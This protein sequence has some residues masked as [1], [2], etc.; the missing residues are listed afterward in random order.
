MQKTSSNL[1]LHNEVNTQQLENEF[2]HCLYNRKIHSKF[3]FWGKKETERYLEVCQQKS[4]IYHHR[5]LALWER[6]VSAILQHIHQ[7]QGTYF[8]FITLGMRDGVADAYLLHALQKYETFSYI[9]V[10]ISE[11]AIIYGLRGTVFQQMGEIES[12]NMDY[13]DFSNFSTFSSRVR[14]ENYHH[15]CIVFLGNTIG[16]LSNLAVLN[17]LRKGMDEGDYLII[18]AMLQKKGDTKTMML[19]VEHSMDMY[20]DA[21]FEQYLLTPLEKVGI[22][23]SHGDIEIVYSPNRY[24]P[25]L[26]NMEVFFVFNSNRTVLYLDQEIPF[27]KGGKIRL[28]QVYMYPEETMIELLETLNFKVEEKFISSSKMVGIY[29]CTSRGS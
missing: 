29:L 28:M 21:A 24:Y 17:K 6:S 14:R 16:Y 1:I 9:P 18:G 4:F 25:A 19:N 26:H 5:E 22:N 3:L 27:L 15:H 13:I 12:Y 2:L 8:N 7:K 11:D 20:S 23:P 10:D